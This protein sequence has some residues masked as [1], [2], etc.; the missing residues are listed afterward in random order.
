MGHHLNF[1]LRCPPGTILAHANAALRKYGRRPGPDPASGHAATVGGVIANNAGGMR[2]ALK[3]DAYHT[4]TA[5]TFVLP[6]GTTINTEEPDAEERFAQLEPELAHLLRH[7][8]RPRL[9]TPGACRVRDQR[10]KG[11]ARR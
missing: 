1:A 11:R 6:S 9:A 10:D 3:R 8:R 7:C 2:C 5:M 4:V